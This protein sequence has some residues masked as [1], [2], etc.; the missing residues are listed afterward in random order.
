MEKRT[1][2]NKRR[3]VRAFAIHRR[4]EGMV[5][6]ASRVRYRSPSPSQL[7]LHSQFNSESI[8]IRIHPHHTISFHTIGRI[9][10]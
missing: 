9:K 2:S 5:T 4:V 7:N 3:E 8:A 10:S 6:A 1:Y